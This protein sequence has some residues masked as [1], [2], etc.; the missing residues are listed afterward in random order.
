MRTVIPSLIFLFV[1]GL[2]SFSLLG[3]FYSL[4]PSLFWILWTLLQTFIGSQLWLL[5]FF[6]TSD[7]DEE[8]RFEKPIQ[9]YAFFSMGLISFLI[10]FTL[11]RDLAGFILMAFDRRAVVYGSA[12][13]AAIIGLSLLCFILGAFIA[14][15]K[16]V[17]KR[18]DIPVQDLPVGLQG[19]KIVQ[20][21]DIHLGTG[22]GVGHASDMVDRANSLSAD[23]IVLTGDIID[24]EVPTIQKELAHLARLKAKHGVYFILGNHE[25]YWKWKDAV[26]AMKKIGIIPLLNE[27]REIQFQ[28]ET[29]FLAGI[30]D[31]AAGHTGGEGPKIPVPP[32]HSKL[33][34]ALIHQ[35]QFAESVAKIRPSYHLQ[36]SG[37]THGGQFFP[38]NLIVD[39]MYPIARGLGKI[40]G[41]WVYVNQGTGYWGP[42][43]RLG[44]SGEVSHLVLA[45][46]KP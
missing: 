23:I 46:Q 40:D 43:I 4:E 28:N 31:P 27:G 29:F 13:S 39:R 33:N 16:V 12:A 37:H 6:F 38:W 42:P 35:P 22:P 7:S 19:L 45:I 2:L 9:K 5:L 14:R 25:C 3:P 21:S 36:L 15:F 8:M 20:L 32:P 10:I 24:G 41:M 11:L 26:E 44:T 1:D 18:V 17:S 30:N 34:I